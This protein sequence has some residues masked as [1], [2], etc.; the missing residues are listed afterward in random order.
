M[1]TEANIVGKVLIM[2]RRHGAYTN[3]NHGSPFQRIG[4][5]DIEGCLRGRF[6][7]FEVKQPGQGHTLT[8]LQ[9][10][11]LEEIKAAGGLAGTVTSVDEAERAIR[12][13]DLLSD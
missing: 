7:A 6:F 10:R 4:R 11:A 12:D 13:W 8:P 1:G 2:L 3:K 5:P 9:T